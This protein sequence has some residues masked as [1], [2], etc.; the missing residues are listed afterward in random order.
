M[1]VQMRVIICIRVVE[2][3]L[4][5]HKSVGWQHDSQDWLAWYLDP[6]SLFS[7]TSQRKGNEEVS[8]GL[9]STLS[10]NLETH[11]VQ[12]CMKCMAPAQ[13]KPGYCH[14]LRYAYTCVLNGKEGKKENK[15]ILI[16]LGKNGS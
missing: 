9:P 5:N 11:S 10:A 14:S 2:I 6:S 3:E 4:E 15:T 7:S 13:W 8:P 1:L 12:T 16:R